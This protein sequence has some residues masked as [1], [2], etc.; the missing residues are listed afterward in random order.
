MKKRRF[1]VLAS[2]VA[3]ALY[4]GLLLYALTGK[5]GYDVSEVLRK[6]VLDATASPEAYDVLAI[7]DSVVKSSFIPKDF[8][9]QTN[10]TA[11]NLAIT[12]NGPIIGYYVLK[13]YLDSGKKPALIIISYQQGY[14]FQEAKPNVL[15]DNVYG[16]YLLNQTDFNEILQN[17]KKFNRCY[18][19][20]GLPCDSMFLPYV[21]VSHMLNLK[22]YMP[23]ILKSFFIY[24]FWT[25]YKNYKKA[26][27]TLGIEYVGGRNNDKINMEA[28]LSTRSKDDL[29]EFYFQSIVKLAQ[30][31]GIKVAIY[32]MPMKAYSLQTLSE[33][34][35]QDFDMVIQDLKKSA[36]K[37]DDLF[38]LNDFEAMDDSYFGDEIHPNEK[39]AQHITQD[40]IRRVQKMVFD[41]F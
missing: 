32:L 18:E 31:N 13:K 11:I 7:G 21:Y 12:A 40:I 34:N 22:N 10:R 14:L 16:F 26:K 2:G 35:K 36:P 15:I 28:F 39:G 30:Q 6:F 24:G 38:I 5:W 19:I 41:S 25:N 27:N 9:S 20:A 1:F 3:M 4:A 37:K 8:A 29:T 23:E 17:A 33:K